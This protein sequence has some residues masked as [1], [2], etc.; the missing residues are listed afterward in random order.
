MHT[1][2]F[3]VNYCANWETIEHVR[4]NLPEFNRV[5]PLAF[6]VK[7]VHTINLCTLVI[8]SQ[9]KKVLWVLNLIA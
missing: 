2:N 6:V 9:Q 8:T 5:S 1:Q 4:E 3:L 7:A